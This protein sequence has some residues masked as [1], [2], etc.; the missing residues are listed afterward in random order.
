[1]ITALSYLFKRE[2]EYNVSCEFTK[3]EFNLRSEDLEEYLEELAEEGYIHIKESVTYGRDIRK[4]IYIT[5][6]GEDFLNNS[7]HRNKAKKEA[8]TIAEEHGDIPISNFVMSIRESENPLD[9]T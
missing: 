3:E 9:W 5:E 4:T 8:R 6:Q 7:A 2:T 1:M